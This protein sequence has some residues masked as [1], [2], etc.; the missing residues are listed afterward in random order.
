M[1]FRFDVNLNDKDYTDFKRFLMIKSPYGKKQLRSFRILMSV[2]YC[3]LVFLLL[4]NSG[5]TTEAFIVSVPVIIIFALSVVF[6]PKC[7]SWV[8]KRQIKSM[9]KSGKM[10]YSP[11]SVM[12]FYEDCFIEITSEN[13]TEQ[14]YSAVEQISFV[15]NRIIYIHINNVMAYLLPLSCFE[16]DEQIRSF[17]DFM[18]TKCGKVNIY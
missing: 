18:K 13:K 2:L 14:K 11:E 7:L 16:S 4:L 8:L 3:L 12:E 5:F 15:D 10:G 6:W 9:K 1:K 17:L